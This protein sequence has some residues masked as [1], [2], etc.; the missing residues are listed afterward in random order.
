MKPA[1]PSWENLMAVKVRCSDCK[2]KI[3]VDDAFAGSVCRCPYCKSIIMVPAQDEIESIKARTSKPQKRP[4]KPG[5]Y[6]P[7]KK[8]GLFATINR[9]K[10]DQRNVVGA[11]PI[12]D[13]NDMP[14]PRIIPGMSNIEQ[15]S[16][17]RPVRGEKTTPE[18]ALP[19]E[20]KPFG[21]PIVGGSGLKG[22]IHSPDEEP[23]IVSNQADDLD[24]FADS[25]FDE[26]S[27]EFSG[28]AIPQTVHV[29]ASELSDDELAAIPT[30]N[31]VRMQGIFSLIIIAVLVVFVAFCIYFGTLWL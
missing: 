12:I 15:P 21:L 24:S 4:D 26:Q 28:E 6:R 14:I 3:A 27:E 5:K 23:E 2:K 11:A 1:R 18:E 16:R 19:S 10:D 20:S 25:S 13:K 30:A 9:R 31:P 22:T 29:D 8:R 7:K 17:P